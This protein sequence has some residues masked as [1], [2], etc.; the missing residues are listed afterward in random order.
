MNIG[1]IGFNDPINFCG[2]NSVLKTKWKQGKLPSVVKGFYGDVL[3]KDNLSLE[4][5]KPRCEGGPTTIANLVLASKQKNNAR[6]YHDINKFA[7][8]DVAKEYLAQFIGVKIKGFDGNKY[9]KSIVKTLQSL[10]FDLSK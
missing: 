1:P 2:Y 8:K 5:L 3:T 4:H 10:G 7:D 9:I 6:G